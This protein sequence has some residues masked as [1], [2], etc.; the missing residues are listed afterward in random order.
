LAVLVP[1]AREHA[2]TTYRLERKAKASYTCEEI[3][4]R[5]RQRSGLSPWHLSDAFEQR[6]ATPSRASARQE[7]DYKLTLAHSPLGSLFANP[8]PQVRGNVP[9]EHVRHHQP[10]PQGTT[11]SEAINLSP[12][13]KP[14]LRRLL[15]GSFPGAGNP[16]SACHAT[17]LCVRPS[18][19]FA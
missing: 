14:Q 10:P 3:D 18:S 19:K 15:R 9:D 4:E 1:L 7:P 11:D 8:R 5:E 13:F 6:I 16:A 12:R 2:P 17:A